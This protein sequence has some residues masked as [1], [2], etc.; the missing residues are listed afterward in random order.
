MGRY[1]VQ[2]LWILA[3]KRCCSICEGGVL[4]VNHILA[5]GGIEEAAAVLITLYI[6]C[7]FP[8]E[9]IDCWPRLGLLYHVCSVVVI[10]AGNV[11]QYRTRWL[12]KAPPSI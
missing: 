11:S 10:P 2:I 3:E 1:Q 8:S 4:G 5:S 12:E 6:T 9:V 7:E